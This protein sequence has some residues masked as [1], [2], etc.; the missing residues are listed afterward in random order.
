MVW[1]VEGRQVNVCEDLD[2]KRALAL[3]LCYGCGLTASVQEVV[4]QYDDAFQVSHVRSNG[5]IMSGYV[6]YP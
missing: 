4:D 6:Q 3:H 1:E 2:W 5:G